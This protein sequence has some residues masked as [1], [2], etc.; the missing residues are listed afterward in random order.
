MTTTTIGEWGNAAAI[1]IPQSFCKQMGIGIGDSVKMFIDERNRIVIEP[2]AE[3]HTL[4][5]RMAEWDGKRYEAREYDWGE[6]VGL[7]SRRN[8]SASEEAGC[9]FADLY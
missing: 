2:I 8:R 5:A 9:L 4:Q 6:P 7:C 1:R 3:Q